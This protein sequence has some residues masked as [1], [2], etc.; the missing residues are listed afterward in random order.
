VDDK[1]LT[2]VLVEIG[3]D[4]FRPSEELVRRTRERVRGIRLMPLVVFL[5]LVLHLL[6]AIGTAIVLFGPEVTWARSAL[7]LGVLSL[8]SGTSLLPVV[9]AKEWVATFCK[10]L[11]QVVSVS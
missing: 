4:R 11:D 1:E 6:M 9:V 7:T 8:L 2:R 5:S 10:Q 3:R